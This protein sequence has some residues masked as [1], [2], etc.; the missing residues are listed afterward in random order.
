MKVGILTYHF[1]NNYGAILQTYAMQSILEKKGVDVEVLNYVSFVQESHNRL[2]EKEFRTKAMLRNI[3]RIP[4]YAKRKRRIGKFGAFR[5]NFL[6]L[7]KLVNNEKELLDYVGQNIELVIVGSDQV[8]NPMTDDFD[9]IYFNIAKS[10]KRVVSYAAS[11]GKAVEKDLDRYR[12]SLSCFERISTREKT[13]KEIIEEII[14]GTEVE[15][16]LD[17]T[18]L[19]ERDRYE[20]LAK[21]GVGIDGE[22]IL[23][24]Y[25]GREEDKK[26]LKYMKEISRKMNLPVYYINANNGRISYQKT[27]INDAGPEDFLRLIKNATVVFTNSFHATAFS[28]KLGVPFYNFEK[29]LS[30]DTR[31]RDLLKRVGITDR[32]VYDF[33]TSM[34]IKTD[35]KDIEQANIIINE[36]KK[37]S[38]AFINTVL[39]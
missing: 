32:A 11:M 23:C 31:K 18:L 35:I 2:W 4:N 7:S 38:E 8:W 39:C 1:A 25:L 28:I 20:E 33:D 10:D 29:K 3:I 34:D 36:I 26:V 37:E 12:E 19:L 14:S 17:P 30:N 9:E 5:K 13:G 27:A 16:V 6:H 15:N 24:Y 22:Y 21:R